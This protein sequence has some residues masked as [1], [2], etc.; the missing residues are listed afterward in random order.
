[1]ISYIS[2]VTALLCYT[3]HPADIRGGT[4]GMHSGG[5]WYRPDG[6]EVKSSSDVF[7]RN[8]GSMV[9]RLHYSNTASST[10][11]PIEGIYYCEIED[12]SDMLQRVHVGLYTSAGGI[13]VILFS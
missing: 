11:P 7:R 10:C 4:D 1:M 9:V 8:R 13:I 6:I 12:A 5:H 2:S 3:N